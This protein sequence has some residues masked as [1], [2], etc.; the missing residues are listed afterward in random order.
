MYISADTLD[1]LM[2]EAFKAVL[3]TGM[4]VKGSKG[5]GTKSRGGIRELM[6]VLLHL[7]NPRARLS[8]TETKGMVYSALGEI[9][10]YLSYSDK[11][12]FIEYYIPAYKKDA[13]ADGTLHG[14]YGPR[15]HKMRGEHDQM[16]NVIKLLQDNPSS[17][18]A[19][20][21]LFDAA[22]IEEKYKEIPCTC[23]LQ[24]LIRDKRL[25]LFTH[26]RSNDA[27]RGLPHDIFAFTMLQEIVARILGIEVGEYYHSA[28]SFHIY[29][30][31][32]EATQL[33]LAE[34]F[35]SALS[36]MPPM[37]LGDP[38]EALVKLLEA[39]KKIR[40][41]DS[42]VLP[43]DIDDYWRDFMYLL[44]AYKIRKQSYNELVSLKK[45]V[46]P[47]YRIYIDKYLASFEP[48]KEDPQHSLNLDPE[49]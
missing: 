45:R 22:D 25:F 38:K 1:D 9:L 44:R 10:W 11:L 18:R 2:N 13:E 3:A 34:G 40:N 21:Q 48:P 46:N 16:S 24:F 37:P 49:S 30:K 8:R 32:V 39:E 14:A 27:F 35:Q 31:D 5:G 43:N 4:T 7:K 12:E 33:Y 19:V 20:I 23:T 17:K 47:I 42:F 26:M 6:G 36:P 15:L 29:E 41:E 28:N